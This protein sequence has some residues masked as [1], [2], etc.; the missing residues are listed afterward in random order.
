MTEHASA[1]RIIEEL[2]LLEIPCTTA[3]PKQ[4]KNLIRPN[5]G[6]IRTTE[7]DALFKAHFR[8]L[9]ADFLTRILLKIDV[10]A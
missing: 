3:I 8:S 2:A 6:V 7:D 10:A 1:R 5:Q 4:R 9:L